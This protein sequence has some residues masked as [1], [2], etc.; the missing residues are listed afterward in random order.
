MGDDPAAK[1]PVTKASASA[2]FVN[3]LYF[4]PVNPFICSSH[5]ALHIKLSVEFS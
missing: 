5:S 1:S 2:A 4:A 3:F